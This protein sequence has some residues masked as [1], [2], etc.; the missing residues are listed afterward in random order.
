[1]I[2][3]GGVARAEALTVSMEK[4]LLTNDIT[5]SSAYK[6]SPDY[7]GVVSNLLITNIWALKSFI[8]R[9]STIRHVLA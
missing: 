2:N 4:A 1:M 7:A 6:R 3:G 9:C 5:L 8:K